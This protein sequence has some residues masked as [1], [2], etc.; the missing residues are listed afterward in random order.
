MHAR[1]VPS[2]TYFTVLVI[3]E[4]SR[5]YVERY[6]RRK[7]RFESI[8]S[9]SDREREFYNLRDEGCI[10]IFSLFLFRSVCEAINSLNSVPLVT[11]GNAFGFCKNLLH[12]LQLYLFKKKTF[13]NLS[14]S[15]EFV[16]CSEFN[17]I[18]DVDVRKTR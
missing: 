4:K 3:K 15:V 14:R 17:Y 6:Y 16:F 13:V 8:F 5:L 7:K 9:L 11:L 18:I 2:L 1:N 10:S 12:V